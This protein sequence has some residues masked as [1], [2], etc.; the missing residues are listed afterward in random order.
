[1]DVLDRSQ[2]IARTLDTIDAARRSEKHHSRLPLV[3]LTV[4]DAGET[5]DGSYTITGHAAVFEQRDGA[6]REQLDPR[7]RAVAAGA[8]DERPRAEPGRAPEHQPRHALRDGRTGVRGVGKLELSTDDVGLRTFALL[9]P[10]SLRPR[11]RSS[12]CAGIID[13]MSFAFTIADETRVEI[14]DGDLMDVLYTI[15]KVGNLY[16]VCACAQ[17]AYPQ[18]D[19]SLRSVSAALGRALPRVAE[20]PSIATTSRVAEIPHASNS[21]RRKPERSA[22]DTSTPPRKLMPDKLKQLIAIRDAANTRAAA[23]LDAVLALDPETAKTDVVEAAEV[24]AREAQDA[25]KAASD[26]VESRSNK[27]EARAS[28]TKVADDAPDDAARGNKDAEKRIS[29]DKQEP[30]YRQDKGGFFRDLA[31]AKEGGPAAAEAYERLERN[32][33]EVQMRAGVNTS[34]TSGG[35]FV[36]PDWTN[37]LWAPLLRVGRPFADQCVNIGTPVSNVWNLPRVTTGA[38]V[39]NQSA[40]GVAVSNTDQVTDSIS[41]TLQTPAGRSIASYQVMDL[42]EPGIDQIIYMDLLAALNAEVD[43]LLLNGSATSQKGV[44]Q[45]SGTNAVTYTQATPTGA[46]FWPFIFQGKSAIEKGAFC[47]VDFTVMHPSTWNWFLSQLDSSNRPLALS[48]TGAAFNAMSEYNKNPQGLAGN[49]GGIPVIVDANVPVNLGAGTNQAQVVLC[50]RSGL[51]VKE[52][53]PVFKVADQTSVTSLQYNF[54]LYKYLQQMF[55]RHPKKFSVIGG[56]GLIVQS[57]F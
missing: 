9:D 33:R 53:G 34:A 46:N 30:T 14:D 24:E 50:N 36:P 43:R 32:N 22:C 54:V 21:P 48:T 12:R 41:A 28:F 29:I 18:T 35:E 38:T 31:L 39:A 44:L 40:E 49:I 11:P 25:A 27:L 6:V 13:Q 15:R 52:G 51:L 2:V 42:S 1:M 23:A 16:D 20:T 37:E 56:T 3:D 55:G 17:G 10:T 26:A 47:G 7:P 4:R 5:G 8:F 57:G 45:L 19:S